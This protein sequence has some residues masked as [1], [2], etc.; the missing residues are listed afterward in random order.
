M[1]T[2]PF[3][4]HGFT[5]VAAAGSPAAQAA[6]AGLRAK[7]YA[8][9]FHPSDS[10]AAFAALRRDVREDDVSEY[11]PAASSTGP[12]VSLYHARADAAA[13]V[14]HRGARGGAAGGSLPAAAPAGARTLPHVAA[15]G[16]AHA[17]WSSASASQLA[18]LDIYIYP[19]AN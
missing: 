7:G 6:E 8:T 17:G 13:A 15:G 16:T 3:A 9:T 18:L 2:G 11:P 4:D 10:P 12:F 1:S 5:W 14:L 19:C